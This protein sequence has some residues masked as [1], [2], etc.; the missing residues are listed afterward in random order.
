VWPRHW[1]LTRDPFAGGDSPYVSLPSHDEALYR[2]V[3][4]IERAERQIVFRA[5][6][7]LGKTTVLRAAIAATRS[8]RRRFALIRAP[9]DRT[10]LLSLLAE[11][12]V[13]PL[14]LGPSSDALWQWVA[15]ALR[16]AALEG[17]QVVVAID[18]CADR[19]D[20]AMRHD[21]EALGHL[22]PGDEPGFSVIRVARTP[23]DPQPDPAEAWTLA[24]GLKR[25]TRS[26]VEVY[27][28]AKLAAAGCAE[29]IFTPRALTRLHARS[30]GVPRGIERLAALSLMAA[31]AR[32]LEVISPEIV[33]G[34]VPEC[35]AGT[36]AECAGHLPA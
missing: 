24:I 4:A 20:P 25:L 13:R 9:A 7:G 6:A 5:E 18:D 35:R 23:G 36:L 8:A 3:Y 17:F 27:L 15:R 32:G 2:L 33:E 22:G 11:Q 19:L 30:A 16:V 10:Q 31:A 14:G 12:F 29:P 28:A 34:V 1:G 26:E 21:L